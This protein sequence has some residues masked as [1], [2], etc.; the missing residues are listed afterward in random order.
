MD[1]RHPRGARVAIPLAGD[2]SVASTAKDRSI[3]I[4]VP[5][6]HMAANAQVMGKLLAE[7]DDLAFLLMTD[8]AIAQ[9]PGDMVI[10][11]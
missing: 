2:I 1:V 6:R 3:G 9:Y 4:V 10:V 11:P 5:L 7:A 8:L